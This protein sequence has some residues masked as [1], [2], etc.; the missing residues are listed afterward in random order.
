VEQG[1][2]LLGGFFFFFLLVVVVVIVVSRGVDSQLGLVN[3]NA[4]SGEGFEV[5]MQ[6]HLSGKILEDGDGLDVKVAEHGIALPS[7]EKADEVTV[8]A[9]R[10]EGHGAG[11]SEGFNGDIGGCKAE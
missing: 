8:D 2:A 9:G 5:A 10:D 1:V 4:S 7:A 3:G 11:G 6:V